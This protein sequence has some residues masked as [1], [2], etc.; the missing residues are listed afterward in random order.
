MSSAPMGTSA[1]LG[2]VLLARAA[3][4]EPAAM[5][6][7]NTTQRQDDDALVAADRVLDQDRQQRQHDR[8][9]EPEPRRD[10]A[11]DPQPAV[12]AQIA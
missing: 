10:Q 6:M 1:R 8:A 7:V 3:S 5:P 12:A 2:R 4:A 11:A 9:D